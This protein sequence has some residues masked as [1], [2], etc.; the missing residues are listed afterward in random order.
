M[1]APLPGAD[2]MVPV[3]GRKAAD[4]LAILVSLLERWNAAINLVAPRSLADVWTRHIA[5]SLQL[6]SFRPPG[7]RTWLDLGSGAG[8]PGMVAALALSETAPEVH[9][10]LVEADVRKAEFLRAVSRETKVEVT[11]LAQRIEDL[12][13]QAADTVSARALAPLTRLCAFAH[14][15]LAPA[16]RAIFP[17][18]AQA[19]AEIRAA[20]RDWRFRVD[21]HASA[22]DPA[23]TILVLS[24]LHHASH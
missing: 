11:I 10:T 6:L 5:D 17:K 20:E 2:M 13:P 22:S 23:G 19:E 4:R 8:F 3:V 14:P 1:T 16:G 12:P 18:G 15:H 9:V 21:R 7:A 24:D